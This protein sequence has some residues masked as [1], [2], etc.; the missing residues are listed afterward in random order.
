M[1]SFCQS[2]FE[3]FDSGHS[4]QTDIPP[5]SSPK[6]ARVDSENI[7]ANPRFRM[8]LDPKPLISE[9][10]AAGRLSAGSPAEFALVCEIPAPLIQQS[11]HLP[12][13][14]TRDSCRFRPEQVEN[15]RSIITRS[16][17]DAFPRGVPLSVLSAGEVSHE[18]NDSEHSVNHAAKHEADSSPHRRSDFGREES[19]IHTKNL[20]GTNR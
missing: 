13:G 20:K 18:R 6:N 16:R 9:P 12:A 15:T 7:V 1:R 3:D 5:T 17:R 14:I 19:C 2:A 10:I 8:I 11:R 4:V